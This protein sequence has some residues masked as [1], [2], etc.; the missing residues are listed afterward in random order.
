MREE[1]RGEKLFRAIGAVDGDLIEEALVYKHKKISWWKYGTIAAG[2]ALL[3]LAGRMSNLF[4]VPENGEDTPD[5]S[6]KSGYTETETRTSEVIVGED[7]PDNTDKSGY[8]ETEKGTTEIVVGDNAANENVN[9]KKDVLDDFTMVFGDAGGAGIM[10]YELPQRESPG[11]GMDEIQMLPV[12][13]NNSI[14]NMENM[15]KEHPLSGEDYAPLLEWVLEAAEYFG[16]EN[17]EPVL[18]DRYVLVENEEISISVD[19]NM[20]LMVVFSNGVRLPEQFN[21]SNEATKEESREVAEYLVEQYADLLGMQN[22]QIAI[23]EG[24]YSYFAKRKR[25]DIYV[26]EKG[27]TDIETLLNYCFNR[28]GFAAGDDGG[29][30]LIYVHRRTLGTVL[31][32]Y[33]SISVEEATRRLEEGQ[34]DTAYIEGE[35][36]GVEYIR[37]VALTYCESSAGDYKPYYRFWVEV[38][39]EKRKNGLNTYVDYYVPAVA[40]AYKESTFNE[41]GFE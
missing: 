2:L 15:R 26:Y 21:L 41:T 38:P 37:S 12:F 6:N 31:G 19:G 39:A 22:P 36:P 1:N 8:A 13:E 27:D 9:K 32:E 20:E 24:E 16:L 34:F 30:S 33:E 29:L 25:N 7:T 40:A 17:V 35:F 18:R 28:A 5:A 11:Q 4:V 10:G 23:W 14:Y 3:V